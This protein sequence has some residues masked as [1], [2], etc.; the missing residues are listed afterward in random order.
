MKTLLF[1]GCAALGLMFA[2]PGQAQA[3]Y[4]GHRDGGHGNV[5]VDVGYHNGHGQVNVGYN[6]GHSSH[7]RSNQGH[8]S[9]GHVNTYR[10]YCPPPVVHCQPVYRAPVTYCPPPVVYHRP[11]PVYYSRPQYGCQGW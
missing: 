8:Y 3:Q 7:Y 11:A 1:A 5:R 10:S 4:Y 6:S 9:H 2:S